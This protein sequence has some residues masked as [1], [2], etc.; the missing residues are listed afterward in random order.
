MNNGVLYAIGAYLLWGLLPIYWKFLG[1]VPVFQVL[2]HR[3]IWSF[4]FLGLTIV[5]SGQWRAFK[6]AIQNPNV[7]RI[8]TLTALLVGLNW[9]IY[10]WAVQQGFIIE[11]SLGYF[12]NPLVS[13][14]MGVVFLKEKLRAGQWAAIAIAAA[15]VIYLTFAYGSLP[16]I[17]LSLAITWAIYALL[18]KIAPL[19]SLYGLTLETSVLLLPAFIYLIWCETQGK[20]LF[21][22]HSLPSD[23]LLI[24]TG[25]ATSTPLLLFASAV[26]R[27]PLSLVGI[28]Q[29][30]APT[31]QF[32]IGLLIYH[33]PFTLSRLV[34][35]VLIWI[36]LIVYAGEGLI[37][38]KVRSN[39]RLKG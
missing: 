27:I 9:F 15:G 11:T 19:G 1:H 23:L 29:Y 5:L 24:A 13:V 16:W 39:S 34:G 14:L 17:S 18:K 35:F 32:L 37:R 30:I 20:V 3:I 10:V 4:V 36:A 21:L 2:S 12:I 22:H 38:Q 7:I 26:S 6:K 25:L 28:L 8:Y 33:E 31:I